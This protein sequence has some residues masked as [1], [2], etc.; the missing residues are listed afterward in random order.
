MV[1][2]LVDWRCEEN[3]RMPRRVGIEIYGF[4]LRFDRILTMDMDMLMNR[5]FE[6]NLGDD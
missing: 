2:H 3:M 1:T 4:G 5:S 6:R